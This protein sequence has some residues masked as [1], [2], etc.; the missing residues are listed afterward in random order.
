MSKEKA[1]VKELVPA[2]VPLRD[3]DRLDRVRKVSHDICSKCTAT[4]MTGFNDPC[5][6]CPW[7]WIMNEIL[8]TGKTCHC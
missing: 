7:N 1:V 4:P 5:W 3:I 6:L 2:F 8:G